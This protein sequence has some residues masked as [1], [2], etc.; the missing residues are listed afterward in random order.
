VSLARIVPI[1]K[2]SNRLDE[3]AA[4]LH[5]NWCEI[6]AD[7]ESRKSRPSRDVLNAIPAS[8]IARAW[9]VS[10]RAVRGWRRA[11]KQ[12]NHRAQEDRCTR[13]SLETAL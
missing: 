7:Y 12:E 13:R 5:S 4:G 6:L 1:G 11:S 10:V 3:I 9:N 2:E 8:A